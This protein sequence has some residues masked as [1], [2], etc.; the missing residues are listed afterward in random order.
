MAEEVD[1]PLTA[2]SLTVIYYI[3][4]RID[5]IKSLLIAGIGSFFGGALRF[6]IST[7]MKSLCGRGF[8]W[9]TLFVNILGSFIFGLLFGIFSRHGQQ[10]N[11][12][13]L[14]LTTG[15]CGGF[16]TFSTF[17]NEAFQ[18]LHN[19]NTISF[20]IY[21]SI[22]LLMGLLLVALGYKIGI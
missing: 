12:M 16:T 10:T 1:N 14:L 15:L 20:V 13:C 4:Y 5:M 8:P 11:S 7:L 18:M 19:G 6:Y 21:I 3:R 22:S 2:H 17:A 9:G